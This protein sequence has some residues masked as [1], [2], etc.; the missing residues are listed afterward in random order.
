MSHLHLVSNEEH[1]RRVM[2]MGEEPGSVH[3]VGMPSLDGAFRSDLPDRAALSVDLGLPLTPPV[4]IVT[5]HPATLDADPVSAARAV[6]GAMAE[7]PATYV[8]TLPNVDPGGDGVAQVMLAAAT[9]PDRVAVR[10]LGERR[11]WGLMRLA[12]AMLGNSSSGV[13]EAPAVRLPVVN[14]GDRQAGRH[15]QG[16]VVDVAADPA[17]VAAALRRVLDPGYRATMPEPDQPLPDGRAGERVAHIIAEW[18]PSRPPRKP[19][20]LVG[21]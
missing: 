16:E 7:V 21:R 10:A 20:M 1:A 9:G 14:V 18:H 12:D 17:E 11:Y 4:V 19:P 15:R 8:L 2:A 6:A 3:I 5:V 13:A